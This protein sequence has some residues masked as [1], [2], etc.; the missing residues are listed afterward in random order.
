MAPLSILSSAYEIA[1][2]RVKDLESHGVSDKLE[3][4]ALSLGQE[5]LKACLESS[6]VVTIQG[7]VS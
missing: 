2:R 1:V 3:T 4:S 5:L 7:Q 6:Q